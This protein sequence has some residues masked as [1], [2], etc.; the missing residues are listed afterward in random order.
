MDMQN[1]RSK[2][3]KAIGYDDQTSR[4]F[5]QFTH[6]PKIYHYYQVPKAIYSGFMAA[7]SKGDYYNSY[8]R[9]HYTAA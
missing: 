7:S 9:D 1:V 6:N 2:A 3:I 5:I 4:L 8:I